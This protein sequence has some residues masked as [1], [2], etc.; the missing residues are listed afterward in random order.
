[1]AVGCPRGTGT[2]PPTLGHEKYLHAAP[3]RAVPRQTWSRRLRG[4]FIYRPHSGGAETTRC[5]PP[6]QGDIANERYLYTAPAQAVPRGP[7]TP[8]PRKVFIYRPSQ[9]VRLQPKQDVADGQ[10]R[11]LYT[12]PLRRKGGQ[13]RGPKRASGGASGGQAWPKTGKRTKRGVKTPTFLTPGGASIAPR[14][15]LL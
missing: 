7:R 2:S 8:Q 11:H 6:R 14:V 13:A 3:F 9:A 1:M 10:E 15:P 4:E 12:A 5:E